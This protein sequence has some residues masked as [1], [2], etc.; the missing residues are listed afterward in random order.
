MEINAAEGRSLLQMGEAVALKCLCDF[1]RVLLLPGEFKSGHHAGVLIE[2]RSLWQPTQRAFDLANPGLKLLVCQ[3]FFIQTGKRKEATVAP[4]LQ[5]E[6]V[7]PDEARDRDDAARRS[8]LRKPRGM[9][10][11][12]SICAGHSSSSGRD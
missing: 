8:S 1:V 4:A 2:A 9:F 3:S 5:S 6:E 11:L 7:W 12:F 10:D